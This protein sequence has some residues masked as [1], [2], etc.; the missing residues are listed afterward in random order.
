MLSPHNIS[1]YHDWQA[2]SSYPVQC[3][4]YIIFSLFFISS[5]FSHWGRC[6]ISFLMPCFLESTHCL[7]SLKKSKNNTDCWCNIAQRGMNIPNTDTVVSTYKDII[8]SMLHVNYFIGTIAVV[9]LC[10]KGQSEDGAL[11]YPVFVFDLLTCNHARFH[12]IYV[13]NVRHAFVILD[14]LYY[15][16]YD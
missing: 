8:R 13:R 6:R 11:F 9:C 4:R 14:Y 5:F 2:R 16:V 12:V 1:K 10:N 7:R 15:F 3:E